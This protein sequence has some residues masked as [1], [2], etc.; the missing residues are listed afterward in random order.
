MTVLVSPTGTRNC[1]VCG[2]GPDR[3]TLFLDE[4][5]DPRALNAFSFSS[6]K[7]PEFMN[8]RLVRCTR[9]DL[10]YVDRPPSQQALAEA[11]HVADYDSSEEAEDAALAYIRAIGPTL[12][13]VR[14]RDA[15]L[16]IG[17]GTGVFLEHLGKAGFVTLVGV[18]PSSAAIAAAPEARR[19]LIRHGIFA[20]KDFAPESFDLVCCFMTMEHV[21]DPGE[22][23]RSAMRLL[24]A[25]GAFVTVTHDWRGPVN[26]A[27]GRRSPIIDIEH[28]QLFSK[29][30]IR[31]LFD[32]AGYRSIET[33]SFV[34][35]YALRYWVRL[36]PLP[37]AFKR[38]VDRTLQG[39][40]VDRVKLGFNVGNIVCAGI[41]DD[42][43]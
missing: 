8:H 25:G 10:V 20:E 41:K 40:G 13:V 30:S 28:M 37:A 24:R 22:V 16:E 38:G 9:C 36:A 5:I 42:G 12:S 18:E 17:A 27:L 39:L 14:G 4:K 1:P 2:A 43:A 23:A 21:R 26:R 34:N 32:S 11:Y 35:R 33:R 31:M 6:R 3:A 7:R 19:T 29:S 15:A